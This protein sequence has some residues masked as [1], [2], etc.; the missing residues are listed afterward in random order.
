M[1]FVRRLVHGK[2]IEHS[3]MLASKAEAYPGK[4]SFRCPTPG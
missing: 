4:A 2:P 1:E 3:L